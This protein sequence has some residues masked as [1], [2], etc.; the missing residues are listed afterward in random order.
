VP[1]EAQILDAH[2]KSVKDLEYKLTESLKLRVLDIPSPLKVISPDETR[3]AVLF[4]GGL[5]CT[6]L[7]R[8]A[9]DLVPAN[10]Y[11]DLLNVAFENPRVVRASKQNRQLQEP[12]TDSLRTDLF[13]NGDLNVAY[14]Q[15]QSAYEA[16]P[17][18]M[19]GRNALREL[20]QVCPGRKWRFVEV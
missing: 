1:Q 6:V 17:D 11:I 10:Q 7:A 4:S 8:M 5:D 15:S 16:C 14:L 9:N 12:D 20:Q 19:T 13:T 18:R 3:L 2:S